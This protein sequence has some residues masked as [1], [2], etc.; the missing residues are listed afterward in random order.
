[1]SQPSAGS[2]LRQRAL[3]YLRDRYMAALSKELDVRQ[4]TFEIEPLFSR[5]KIVSRSYTD[6]NEVGQFRGSHSVT[7]RKAD[8]QKVLPHPLEV[9]LPLPFRYGELCDY[10]YTRYGM[11]IEDNDFTLSGP[12]D[13]MVA[14]TAD[15]VVTQPRAEDGDILFLTALPGA[16][17]WKQ[18]SALL[19]RVTKT[20]SA[21]SLPS[22]VAQSA[23]AQLERLID[24]TL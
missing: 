11:I 10:L 4:V 20:E 8:L 22:L 6:D 19:L 12:T 21:Q 3:D 24:F 23:P 9:A 5:L 16:V 17:L 13:P 15:S 14:L 2:P 7:Y 1:M 18:G